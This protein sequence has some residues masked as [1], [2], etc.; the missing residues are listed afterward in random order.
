MKETMEQEKKDKEKQAFL[1]VETQHAKEL[2]KAQ[3]KA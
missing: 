3:E 1:A 2:E